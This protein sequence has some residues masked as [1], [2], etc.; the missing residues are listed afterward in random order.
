MFLFVESATQNKTYLICLALSG[1]YECLLLSGTINLQYLI[2]IESRLLRFR[3]LNE[4]NAKYHNLCLWLSPV[5]HT[6]KVF[7][8]YLL[9]N[10]SQHGHFIMIF[11]IIQFLH[12][13]FLHLLQIFYKHKRWSTEKAFIQVSCCSG[14]ISH[15]SNVRLIKTALSFTPYHCGLLCA[16]LLYGCPFDVPIISLD[17]ASDEKTRGNGRIWP[18]CHQHDV[19]YLSYCP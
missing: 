17:V 14:S 4:C 3:N 6:K 11:M 13:I 8:M 18:D 5:W 15:L 19:V 1:T 2:W 10:K 7:T 16:L 9:L 12:T